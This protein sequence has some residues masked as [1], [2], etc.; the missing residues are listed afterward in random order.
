MRPRHIN[1]LRFPKL[2]YSLFGHGHVSNF[3][4][5]VTKFSDDGRTL[6]TSDGLLEGGSFG[7][8]EALAGASKVHR[9]FQPWYTTNTKPFRSN[10]FP[11]TSF[12]RNGSPLAFGSDVAV[13][14]VLGVVTGGTFQHTN[15]YS[16][17]LEADI[18]ALVVPTILAVLTFAQVF[19]HHVG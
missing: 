5:G 1:T 9:A 12:A 6:R 17:L 13:R 18:L 8:V 3:D 15:I 19:F 2:L 7:F 10:D 11:S 14:H 16:P 4:K